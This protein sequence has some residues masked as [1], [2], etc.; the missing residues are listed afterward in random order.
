[1]KQSG[2]CPK[3]DGTHIWNDAHV[4][5]FI[6]NAFI[7]KPRYL[8]VSLKKPGRIRWQSH[9]AKEVAYVCIDCGYKETYIDTEGLDIIREHGEP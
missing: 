2:R 1:M 6:T 9:A 4:P 5:Y 8:L 3:C 7:Q